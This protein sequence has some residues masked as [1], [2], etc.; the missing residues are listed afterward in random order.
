MRKEY[1]QCE[2]LEDFDSRDR[3]MYN[4]LA[5]YR[6]PDKLI[7][8]IQSMSIPLLFRLAL[9]WVMIKVNI[10]PRDIACKKHLQM[11]RL[12]DRGCADDTHLMSLTKN[13]YY[14]I[15]AGLYRSM[16]QPFSVLLVT[17]EFIYRYR[18]RK[19]LVADSFN[20][21]IEIFNLP[22]TIISQGC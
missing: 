9:E 3:N 2:S 16:H 14:G 21:E 17:T 10:S 8:I 5:N 15:Q 12:E 20:V 18:N 19:H 13:Y 1:F 6:I 7:A 22:V 4:V 11:T